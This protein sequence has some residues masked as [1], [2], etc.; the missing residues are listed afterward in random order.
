MPGHKGLYGPQG[1]GVLLCGE[2]VETA[3][4]LEGGTGSLSLQQAMPDFLPDRLEAGTHNMPGIAG[5]LAGV[6]FV[7]SQGLGAICRRERLLALLAADGLKKLPGVRVYAQ[8]DLADQAGV[9]SFTAEAGRWRPWPGLWRSGASPSGRGS[10][11][12][13]RPT[14]P[15]GPWTP[16]PSVPAFPIGTPRRR[17]PASWRPWGKSSAEFSEQ[18]VNFYPRLPCNLQAYFI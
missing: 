14:R 16:A 7:R 6:Q 13:R 8:P 9:V 18:T 15:P 5:L 2:G 4:L 17:W 10:T 12:R 3:A 11:A 1:T